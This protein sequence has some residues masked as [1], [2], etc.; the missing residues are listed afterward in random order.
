MVKKGNE[1]G[2]SD[3]SLGRSD[4]HD[5]KDKD[6]AVK[7]VKLPRVRDEGE[8]HGIHHQFDGHED[9][10]AVLPRQDAADSDGEDDGAQDQEPVRRNHELTA[11][12][13]LSTT[14]PTLAA[15]RRI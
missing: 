10:D 11:A 1:N 4:G 15:S 6:E 14:A 5:E 9:R 8:V 2:Q 13:R 12:R 3:S 7:L